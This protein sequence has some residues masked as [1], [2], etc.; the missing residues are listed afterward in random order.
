[1]HG[2]VDNVFGQQDVVDDA[3]AVVFLGGGLIDAPV[4]IDDKL[5]FFVSRR[6]AQDARSR[7]ARVGCVG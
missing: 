2:L 7:A 4:A 6:A 1:V 3:I 5:R